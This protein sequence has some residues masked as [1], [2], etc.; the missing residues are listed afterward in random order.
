MDFSRP[1]LLGYTGLS[2][3]LL[4]KYIE[5]SKHL[6]QDGADNLRP[7]AIGSVIGTHAGSGAVAVAFFQNTK[8]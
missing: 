6:W 8:P 5:D 3:V 4:K 1:L 7:T 2:D